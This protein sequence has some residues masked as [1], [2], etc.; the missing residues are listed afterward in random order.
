MTS[1][2]SRVWFTPRS[3][4]APT[5]SGVVSTQVAQLQQQHLRLQQE[6]LAAKAEQQ[7]LLAHLAQFRSAY[8]ALSQH[9]RVLNHQ[10]EALKV[11]LGPKAAAGDCAA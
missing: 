10:V 2:T 5:E 9:N 6:T 3:S 1:E 7:E 11:I 8:A 4:T